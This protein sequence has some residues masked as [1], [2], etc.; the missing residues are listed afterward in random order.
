[1]KKKWIAVVVILICCLVYAIVKLSVSENQYEYKQPEETQSAQQINADDT[2]KA[3]PE[4]GSGSAAPPVQVEDVNKPEEG[5]GSVVSPAQVEAV[6]KAFSEFLSAIK[7]EDYEQAWKLV[8]ES[9]KSKVSFEEFKEPLSELGAVLVET[10]IRPESATNID[11]RVRLP[12][13]IPSGE[14]GHLTFVQEDGQWKLK[15]DF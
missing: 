3:T 6:T 1:M 4:E 15:L 11:G 9:S 5:S 13:T 12:I 2:D 10:T 14:D 7:S 8:S